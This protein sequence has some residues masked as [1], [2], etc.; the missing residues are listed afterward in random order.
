MVE[1]IIHHSLKVVA[2]SVIKGTSGLAGCRRAV[3]HFLPEL[4][5]VRT[6]YETQNRKA[7]A[8][9]KKKNTK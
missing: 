1:G 5:V 4:T 8:E 7:T 3:C 6:Y 2:R 9:S